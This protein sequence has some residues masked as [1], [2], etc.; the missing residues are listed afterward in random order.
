MQRQRDYIEGYRITV[1]DAADEGRRKGKSKSKT[2][3][4]LEDEPGA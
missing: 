2:E 4:P 3:K 1:L